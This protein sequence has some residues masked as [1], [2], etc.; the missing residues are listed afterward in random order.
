[1]RSTLEYENIAEKATTA[2]SVSAA[3]I[4]QSNMLLKRPTSDMKNYDSDKIEQPNLNIN[5][6]QPKHDL[7]KVE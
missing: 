6:N 4:N 1:M 2:A 5:L 7:T 3:L